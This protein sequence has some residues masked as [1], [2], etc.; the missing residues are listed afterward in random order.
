[1]MSLF[2]TAIAVAMIRA[3]LLGFLVEAGIKLPG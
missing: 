3:G 1:M 2:M